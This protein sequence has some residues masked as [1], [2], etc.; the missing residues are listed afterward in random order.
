[1]KTTSILIVVLLV[2]G[3]C[4]ASVAFFA[5]HTDPVPPE[6]RAEWYLPPQDIVWT[7]TGPDPLQNR[8]EHF[9]ISGWRH[10]SAPQF[11]VLSPYA[12]YNNY[13]RVGS[14]DQ[15]MIADWYFTEPAG[16]HSAREQLLGYL[17]Q[18]GSVSSVDFNGTSGTLPDITT[19][20]EILQNTNDGPRLPDSIRATGYESGNTSGYFLTASRP[21]T[22]IMMGNFWYSPDQEYYIVYYGVVTPGSL[23]R[24]H[25]ILSDLVRETWA[26]DARF[27]EEDLTF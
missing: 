14:D 10:T 8:T 21:G 4:I 7:A 22:G 5:N 2:A 18:T 15:Y 6:V 16:F 19:G 27:S 12:R 17:R 3:V 1:M 25:T 9:V 26:Y 20:D 24:Q 11:P 13:S 23:S